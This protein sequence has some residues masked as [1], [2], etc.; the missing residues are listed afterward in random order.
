MLTLVLSVLAIAAPLLTSHSPDTQYEG[1]AEVPP[2]TR[3]AAVR[4]DDGRWQL[5]E[6]VERDPAGGGRLRLVRKEWP[7]YVDEQRV[8]NLTPTGIADSRFFPLGTDRL[9]RDLWTRILYGAR[10]SLVIGLLSVSL[11]FTVGMTIGALAATGG[12]W[13]DAFLMRSVDALL[14]FPWLF[15]LLA[16]VSLFGSKTVTIVLILGGT[17]WMSIS[18]LVRAELLSLKNRDFVLAAR[19]VGES[20]WR[21]LWQHLLPNALGPALVQ[22]T[23]LLGNVILLE[24]S[25]S[26][27]GMGIQPPTPSWGNIVADGRQSLVT[28]WWISTLPGIAVAI[29]VVAFNLLGDGLRDL[30]D[31]RL[32]QRR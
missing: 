3:L 20:P 32:R 28:G 19:A 23:L 31:P 17:S 29:T 22:T 9:G 18:R 1:A 21:I 24:S 10:I 5:A 8:T 27:L 13:L 14:A 25:L 12:R 4:L 2:G 16:V 6:R 7:V 15:L 11:A 30:L 26:F